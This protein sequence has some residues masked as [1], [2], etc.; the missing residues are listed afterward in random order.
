MEL[1]ASTLIVFATAVFLSLTALVGAA[2][3]ATSDW[4]VA[5]N[6]AEGCR[7]ETRAVDGGR[8]LGILTMRRDEDGALVGEMVLPLNLF[9][10]SGVRAQVDN[11]R[12]E[13]APQLLAC[14][15]R[16]CLAAFKADGM[17]LSALQTGLTLDTRIVDARSGRPLSLRFSLRGFTAASAKL[18]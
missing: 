13:I 17:L 5:C 18:R 16:G 4:V 14:T 12:I 11:G 6:D 8:T 7:M 15:A 9:I 2:D 3:A 1:R 10:P